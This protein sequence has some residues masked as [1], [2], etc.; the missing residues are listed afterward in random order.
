MQV[1]LP[2]RKT[3]SVPIASMGA[4]G[5][6]TK[7][8]EKGRDRVVTSAYGN[9]VE[10][11]SVSLELKSADSSDINNHISKIVYVSDMLDDTFKDKQDN[12]TYYYVTAD[13]EKVR[14][15]LE[16]LS[17]V[18]SKC[19]QAKLTA[20]GSED[21]SDVVIENATAAQTLAIFKQD[22]LADRIDVARDFADF[23]AVVGTPEGRDSFANRL[24]T[25][26][27]GGVIEPDKPGLTSGRKMPSN[28]LTKP[29]GERVSL[30]ITVEGI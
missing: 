20:L 4:G 2:S 28:L 19:K 15:L 6:T 29:E 3:S 7:I 22:K 24:A 8:V 9:S 12:V 27:R 21:K 23:N 10:V 17:P 16:E 13:I 18:W 30:K 5:G 25:R 14:V 1:L 11:F 26:D